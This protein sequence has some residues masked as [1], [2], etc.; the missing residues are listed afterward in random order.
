MNE[1]GG[2]VPREGKGDGSCCMETLYGRK[3]ARGGRGGGAIFSVNY[4]AI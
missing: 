3:Y 2:S 1:E 4:M